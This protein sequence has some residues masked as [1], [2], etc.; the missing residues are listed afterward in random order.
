MGGQET[1]DVIAFVCAS[2]VYVIYSPQFP[3]DIGK[4]P[5]HTM[6]DVECVIVSGGYGRVE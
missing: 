3:C 2:D 5:L 1:E 4:S 6:G